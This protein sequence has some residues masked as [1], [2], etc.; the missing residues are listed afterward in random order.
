[1][2]LERWP[3]G[4]NRLQVGAEQESRDR[5]YGF[6][7]PEPQ[8]PWGARAPKETPGRGP[9]KALGACRDNRGKVRVR[10]QMPVTA[11]SCHSKVLSQPGPSACPSGVAG[12]HNHI[13]EMSLKDPWG[14]VGLRVRGL[15]V[16][17]GLCDLDSSEVGA[18]ASSIGGPLLAAQTWSSNDLSCQMGS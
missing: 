4:A 15:R 5:F 13:I 8:L 11:R 2:L 12:Q 3:S 16:R 17:T 6:G 18:G 14:L 1:V 9:R 7:K 10:L